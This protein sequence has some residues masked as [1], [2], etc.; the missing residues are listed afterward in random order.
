MNENKVEIKIQTKTQYYFE[1]IK[2]WLLKILKPI[3]F[4][5]ILIGILYISFYIMLFFLAL[6]AISYIIKT[7][8]K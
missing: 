2:K 3:F 1:L 8:K 7:F 4:I 6:I 5:I